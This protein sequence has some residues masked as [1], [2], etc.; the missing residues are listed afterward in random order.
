M[1]QERQPPPAATA[2]PDRVND[3][4]EQ[5]LPGGFVSEVVRIGDTVR[6]TAPKRAVFVRS[7]LRH[8][9]HH[10]WLGAPRFLGVDEHG[11]EILSFIDGHV[12]WQ[13]VQPPQVYSEASLIR[14]AELVRQFHD[15][16]HGTDL[17]GP[18]EVV[19]HND[20]SPKN[21][22]YRDTSVGLRPVAFIDWDDAAPG[23]RIHDVAQ[24]CSTYLALGPSADPAEAAR[25]LRVLAD[26]YALA[27]R[28]QLVDTIL[29]LQERC[30]CRIETDADAGN[31]AAIQM[32]ELG[33]PQ[34]ARDAHRWTAENRQLL[35]QALT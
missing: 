6:R 16:T 34:E 35:Q 33:I 26:A 22:I 4:A 18:E 14:V 2:Q 20:L 5:A 13:R 29:S 15:L 10:Q 8:F 31:P 25:M 1:Q 9:E 17:A 12:A 28:S 24:M 23:P 21:T 7:L 11:R 27:D 19:C 3:L 32:R 30:W